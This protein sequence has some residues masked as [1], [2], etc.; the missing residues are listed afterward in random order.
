MKKRYHSVRKLHLKKEL[1]LRETMTLRREE[2]GNAV[3]VLRM[4][5]DHCVGHAGAEELKKDIVK[6]LFESSGGDCSINDK[7]L[8]EFAESV[9]STMKNYCLELNG[10]SRQIRVDPR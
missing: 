10:N 3:N 9:I 5:F 6:V 7:E 4:A 2:D 1:L 8:T